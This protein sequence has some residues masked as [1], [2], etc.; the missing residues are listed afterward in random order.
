MNA[1]IT[2]DQ[3]TDRRLGTIG[4]GK[5]PHISQPDAFRSLCKGK[6]ITPFEPADPAACTVCPQCATV[7]TNSKNTTE[8]PENAV[9]ENTA[10][11]T[12]KPD[13]EKT[14]DEIRAEVAADVDKI[15]A[16]LEKLSGDKDKDKIRALYDQ[17][18]NEV[19]R[20]KAATK[21]AAINSKLNEAVAKAEN[22]KASEI[23]GTAV[24]LRAET[25]SLEQIADY[26]AIRENAAKIAAKGMKSEVDAQTVARQMAEAILDARL[27]V[28]A[29]DGQADIKGTR[30]VSRDMT[31]EFYDFG[32]QTLAAEGWSNDKADI[33]DL[34]ESFAEKVKYQ[35]TAVVP[36]F[37]RALDDSPEQFKELFP[38]VAEK[39][40]KDGTKPSDTMFAVFGINPKSRAELAAERRAKKAL[41]K[42]QE[43]KPEIA[44]A[45]T[46]DNADKGDDAATGSA[47]KAA[48]APEKTEIDELLEKVGGSAEI[49]K[50]V[51]PEE[52]TAEEKKAVQA[53]ILEFITAS[54]EWLT[55]ALGV[56]TDAEGD[57]AQDDAGE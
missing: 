7:Y 52:L 34:R 42:G 6:D 33:D 28:T 36:E 51:D 40:K 56:D 45:A 9:T 54:Q 50:H 29:K 14:A 39:A 4:K 20:I 25:T 13:A 46:G 15:V 27:R 24:A 37:V 10:T 3:I 55:K 30:Q 22:R 11:A 41:E 31:G 35:L 47:S 23:K 5:V 38:K 44:P 43:K 32:V 17:G 26:K 21:K 12:A 19:A 8:N 48:P 1:N 18:K 57:A 53:T 2:A 16:E 49:I